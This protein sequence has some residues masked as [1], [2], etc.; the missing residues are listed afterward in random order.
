[1]R[2]GCREGLVPML[3]SRCCRPASF[4]AVALGRAPSVQ[5]S[6][7]APQARGGKCALVPVLVMMTALSLQ[8]ASAPQRLMC[9]LVSRCRLLCALRL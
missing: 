2:V 3:T 5:V 8:L 1:M 7:T 4:R 6:P 9:V